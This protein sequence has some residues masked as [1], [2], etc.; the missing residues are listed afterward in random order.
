MLLEAEMTALLRNDALVDSAM[1][2]NRRGPIGPAGG[3][4]PGLVRASHGDYTAH[5]SPVNGKIFGPQ[6]RAMYKCTLIRR[7]PYLKYIPRFF[8]HLTTTGQ[9]LDASFI[10]PIDMQKPA[11]IIQNLVFRDVIFS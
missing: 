2:V 9:F 8:Q 7:P 11:D 1:G 6:S 5:G 3:S 4:F 10:V